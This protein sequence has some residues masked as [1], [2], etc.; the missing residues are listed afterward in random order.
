MNRIVVCQTTAGF[1]A[2]LLANR[3]KAADKTMRVVIGFDGRR[4]SNVFARDVAE[5]LSGHGIQATLLPSRL[6]TPVL[7]YAVRE[8]NADAGVMVTASHNPASDNGYKVYLGG[9]DGGSQIISPIDR[10]IEKSI[11]EIAEHQTLS[12]IP[13]SSKLVRIAESELIDKYIK[14]TISA[15]TIQS[16]EATALS[17]VYSAMHGVGGEVFLAAMAAAGFPKPH[18]VEEQFDSDPDFPTVA[19]P[20]PEEQG[21]L[22]LSFKKARAV[23]ANLIIAHDPDADRLAVALPVESEEGYKALTGNQV[24]AILGWWS[25]SRAQDAGRHGALA[26][27]IVSSPVLGKIAAH[28]GLGHEE[29]LTGFKYVS[30][31]PGLIFGFEEALGYLVNP[32]VVRDKDGISAAL[33]ILDLAQ[34]LAAEGLSLW[35]YLATIEDTVGGFASGQI[36]IKTDSSPGAKPLTDLVRAAAPH[37]VGELT[38]TTADDFLTGVGG[39]PPDN[40]LR[41]YL[42]DGSRV[43]VRPS[44][45]EPKIKVYLD[46][47]GETRADAELALATLES[48]V[49]DLLD[50]LP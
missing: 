4:Q 26:N 25:A 40:I 34:G 10:H 36:T 23:G 19:F 7:A 13:R 33:A 12:A 38:V 16:S 27:S 2:Y 47:A 46:T 42:D 44:G 8:L 39:F 31:V 18:V 37:K 14:A 32:E 41:Y 6:P 24:G 48:A 15:L 50:S 1:A 22:N 49:R 45:T 3:S 29:T 20:N 5:V 43:I 30:R 11:R 21:A 28:F 35:D 9:E 17:T